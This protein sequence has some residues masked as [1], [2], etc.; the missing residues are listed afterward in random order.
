M[1]RRKKYKFPKTTIERLSLYFRALEELSTRGIDTISSEALG[2]KLNIKSS[3]IRKDLSYFGDFGKRGMGYDVKYL[4]K[5]LRYILGLD[6]EWP[7][8]T[9]GA[10]HMGTA[11]VYY[12]GFKKRGFNIKAIFDNDKAKI[13]Q[14][15]NGIQIM[16]I[17]DMAGFVEENQIEIGIIAVPPAAAQAVADKMVECGIKAILNFAP[18]ALQIEGDVRCLSV[19]LTTKL[20]ALAYYMSYSKDKLWKILS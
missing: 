17:D 9:A 12:E 16:S 1:A 10:G 8:I 19:D 5:E 3:Q 14:K 2:G 7:V 6:R 4:L 11:L 20:E 15:E 13:G 18:V